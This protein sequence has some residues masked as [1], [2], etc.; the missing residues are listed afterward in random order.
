[1]FTTAALEW[2]EG[3]MKSDFNVLAKRH[4]VTKPATR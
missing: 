4:A 2:F 3:G 1:M